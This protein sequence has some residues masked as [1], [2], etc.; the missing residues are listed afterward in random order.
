MNPRAFK[1]VGGKARKPR[2]PKAP[3]QQALQDE[4][5]GVADMHHG[6]DQI[7]GLMGNQHQE[8]P[9][10]GDNPA[11]ENMTYG[12]PTYDLER[13][14]S[15]AE[16][17]EESEHN[18]SIRW[19]PSDVPLRHNPSQDLRDVFNTM[20]LP[21][22]ELLELENPVLSPPRWSDF[23]FDNIDEAVETQQCQNKD[24]TLPGEVSS[25]QPLIIPE[26]HNV[27]QS[28]SEQTSG[29]SSMT[30]IRPDKQPT[31]LS[32]PL[33]HLTEHHTSNLLNMCKWGRKY[34]PLPD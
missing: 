24:D 19:T 13:Q 3:L 20:L 4:S 12:T 8:T 17:Q 33:F 6:F 10:E 1:F 5:H 9:I 16:V 11:A 2:K 26:D 28:F 22:N 7:I 25:S 32:S 29:E 23:H 14:M 31:N 34:I 30:Q 21:N 15:V 18:D 27:R